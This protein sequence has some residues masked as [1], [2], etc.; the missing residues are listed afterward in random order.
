VEEQIH[1]ERH[2]ERHRLAGLAAVAGYALVS[3]VYFGVRPLVEGGH[4]F[5]GYAY[6]PQIFIWAFA[7]WPHAVLHGENPFVTHAIWDPYGVNLTWSTSVPGLA[8]LF[9]PLTLTVGPILSYDVAAVLLPALAAWTAYLLCRHLTRS[10]WPSLVGG[11]L[12]GFSS[13]VVA[14]DGYGGHVNLGSV[15]LLPAIAL[16][17]LRFLDGGLAGRGFILRLAPLLALQVLFSTEIALGVALAIVIGLPLLYALVPSRRGGILRMLAPLTGAGALA[18]VLT[19]PFLYYLLSGGVRPPYYAQTDEFDADIANVF[20]PTKLTIA[21]GTFLGGV[22]R[23][24]LDNLPEQGAYIGLPTL[25]ILVLYS[26]ERWRTPTVRFL[27]AALAAIVLLSFGARATFA[28]HQLVPLPWKLIASQ[29]VFDNVLTNRFIVLATLVTAVVVALWT[30]A[31][32]PGILRTVLPALGVIAVMPNLWHSGLATT[33]DIPPFFTESVYR[34]CIDPGETVLPFPL[35]GSGNALLWQVDEG[36]RFN[37]AA[38]DIGPDIPV[39]FFEPSS[40][41]PVAGGLPLGVTDGAILKTF[42]RGKGVTS[43]VVDANDANSYA[44]AVDQVAKPQVVGGVYLYH[45]TPDAPSCP[46]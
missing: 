13:Y 42:L 44:G 23:R 3:F 41:A 24:F 36:F 10:L 35:R 1:S 33:Y 31:R 39:Q 46:S 19:A 18:A 2:A 34:T 15:F 9:A 40:I 11:Y 26:R 28:G 16:V 25:L 7:W 38:G 12:Y 32:R 8:L 27:L 4:Q 21:G 22:S 6:D 20:V 43:I 30:A 5:I 29:P 45:L 14:Q 37:M 17:M